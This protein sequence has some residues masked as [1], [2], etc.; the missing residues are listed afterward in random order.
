MHFYGLLHMHDN[1]CMIINIWFGQKHSDFDVKHSKNSIM[2]PCQCC[3]YSEVHNL[4][5]GT[6]V[7]LHNWCI[8]VITNLMKGTAAVSNT[9]HSMQQYICASE[10][11]NNQA[12]AQWL[13]L[14]KKNFNHHL[15]C[16]YLSNDM[17]FNPAENT[18]V[19]LLNQ[20]QVRAG[21][22]VFLFCVRL[23]SQN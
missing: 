5:S 12:R 4:Q 11:W 1:V 23:E 7:L 3:H 18:L 15:V 21:K 13:N 20:T 22:T 6:L 8:H 17:V 16:L 14:N 19:K 9:L 2:L 10:G